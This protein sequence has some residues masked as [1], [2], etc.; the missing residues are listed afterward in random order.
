MSSPF[1]V[2][3]LTPCFNEAVADAAA[4]HARQGRKGTPVPFIAHLLGVASIALEFGADEDQAI[5]ALFHD[6]IEDAPDEIGPD[7]VRR[8]IGFKYGA[9]VLSI[10][11]GC[12]DADVKPKPP[13]KTRKEQYVDHI[14]VAEPSVLLVS[15]ADKLHNARA[16]LADYRIDGET[17]WD[18]FNK[19]AGKRGTVGYYRGLVTAFRRRCDA[20]N[21]AASA[22]LRRLLHELDVVVST[23]ESE[24]GCTGEWPVPA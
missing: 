14:A 17:L 24:T 5:A 1:D 2:R 22:P 8:W 12:T 6:A 19:E 10:V 20:L 16:V 11:E 4:L 13:W 7:S 3:R 9:T 21:V 18:R 23:L 15:A